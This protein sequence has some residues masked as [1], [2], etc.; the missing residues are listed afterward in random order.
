MASQPLKRIYFDTNILYR[1]PHPPNDIYSIFGVAKWLGAQL[2]MPEVVEGELEAQFVR[3]VT[4]AYDAAEQ[5]VKEINRLCRDVIA[6]DIT[7]TRPD[8][9]DLR[10]AFRKRSDDLKTHFGISV[11]PLPALDVRMFV[12]MAISR[13]APFEERVASG[14]KVVTGL[15]DAAILFSVLDH[16]KTADDADRC[17]LISNDK[18]FH[19]AETRKLVQL[20][21]NK[22]ETFK[23]VSTLFDDLYNHVW[24]ATRTA[25]HAEMSQI[26]ASLNAQKDD[27]S[28]QIFPFVKASDVGQGIWK[29]AKEITASSVTEFRYVLTELPESEHRPPHAETYSRPDGSEVKI[30]AKAFTQIE[31]AVETTNWLGLFAFQGMQ[32]PDATPKMENATF[33]ETLNLS[34][35]GT[36]RT[37]VIGNF[38]V[39]S[40]EAERL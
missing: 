20:T 13:T 39:T 31:A 25:W 16:M 23:K 28:K 26:E 34:L 27:L 3:S 35:T 6:I 5:D 21:G 40:V 10:A 15:Q 1:W 38:K 14:D 24:D 18:I 29:R 12:D 2:L 22:L 7:G 9:A 17:A 4:A 33:T 8:E 30:S 32:P 19:A 11:I 37:G 36:V